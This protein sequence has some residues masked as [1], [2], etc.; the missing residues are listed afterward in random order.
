MANA[1]MH[2]QMIDVASDILRWFTLLNLA[3][4]WQWMVQKKNSISCP[5][6]CCTWQHT[7]VCFVCV[8][9]VICVFICL[10]VVYVLSSHTRQESTLD[11]YCDGPAV[12]SCSNGGSAPL[13]LSRQLSTNFTIGWW[14]LFLPAGMKYSENS[15]G[16]PIKCNEIPYRNNSQRN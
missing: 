8:Y 12:N 5:V 11:V 1:W 3:S 9:C 15:F 16:E 4:S 7:R 6:Q 13:M 2:S 14:L 10:S